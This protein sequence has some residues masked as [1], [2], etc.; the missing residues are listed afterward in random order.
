MIINDLEQ[1]YFKQGIHAEKF[2]CAFR[3]DCSKNHVKFTEA[4]SAYVPSKYETSYPRIAFLSLD[5]GSSQ[6]KITERTPE[7]VK[8]KNENYV[9]SE[10]IRGRHWYET[11]FWATQI[12]NT[13]GKLNIDISDSKYYFAL[14]PS[15]HYYTRLVCQR[16]HIFCR[17]PAGNGRRASV[18]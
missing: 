7:G 11:H 12:I 9:V 1:L 14:R 16:R 15:L 10:L 2:E 4:K 6:E 18:F 3:N 8:A 5:S 13:I 17:T